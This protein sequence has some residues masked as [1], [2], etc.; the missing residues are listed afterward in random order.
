MSFEVFIAGRY[1]RVK[2]KYAFTSLIS[3]LSVV[4]I[5]VGVMVLIAVIS[6]MSGA[7]KDLRSRI[8]GVAAQVIVMRYGGPFTDYSQTMDKLESFENVE[9]TT[10]FI[11]AQAM[12]RSAKG[13]SMATIKGVD[14]ESAGNVIHN[15][16]NLAIASLE[17]PD[18][19]DPSI[20]SIPRITMGKVLADNLKLKKG[21]LV[22]LIS[23]RGYATGAGLMPSMKHFELSGIFDAGMYDFNKS[24]ALIHLKDAQA[25][26]GIGDAVSG[27]E[28][29]TTDAFKAHDIAQKIADQL[30]FPYWV[31]DW[32]QMNRNLFAS[33]K[34]QKI[35]MFI[36]LIL[37]ILVAAFNIA[38]ALIMNVTE[39]TR[40]I[41]IMKA[42]GATNRSIRKIFVMKGL[43]LSSIGTAIGVILGFGVCLLLKNYQ[44]I[45]LPE[46]IYY[47][48]RLPVQIELLD[49][50]VVVAATFLLCLL[51]SLY[52]A[53]R[54]AKLNPVD[55]IRFN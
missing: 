51:A 30:G 20:R 44:F 53:H 21:D 14:P 22:T 6:V 4:G 13:V 54:A 31:R 32:M 55:G 41:S 17:K 7:E 36:I 50:L 45:D 43:A 52:P 27:V 42:M 47:F 3:F 9:A 33:L 16:N 12:L 25:L 23:P 19:H 29:R 10:P 15:V 40:A 26:A 34:L 35:V 5:A 28:I 18:T 8:L 24:F 2:Q 11:Y 1:T 48:S 46:D 38:T 37:I 39:K 49:V